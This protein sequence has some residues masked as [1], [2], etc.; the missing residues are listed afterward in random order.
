MI[1]IE[2]TI[3]VMLKY[4]FHNFF[5]GSFKVIRTRDRIEK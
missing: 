2:K 5:S 3:T 1:I 4:S